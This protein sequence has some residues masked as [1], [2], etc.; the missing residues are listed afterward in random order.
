ML[1]FA[2]FLGR[3][4]TSVCIMTWKMR[5]SFQFEET[6]ARVYKV[7]SER[8]FYIYVDYPR[9]K[10]DFN[11][12]R[13]INFFLTLT[14]VWNIPGNL[15]ILRFFGMNSDFCRVKFRILP[16]WDCWHLLSDASKTEP[17]KFLS[18]QLFFQQNNKSQNPFSIF[19][20][21]Y[22]KLAKKLR[23]FKN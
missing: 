9:Q 17:V 5:P 20:N 11:E 23:I 2:G 4:F 3:L 14:F 19:K 21:Y 13:E 16:C 6:W 10:S 18:A 22:K 7:R 1:N 12:I 15:F 8:F